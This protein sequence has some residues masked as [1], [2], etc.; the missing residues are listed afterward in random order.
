[1][2]RLEEH[3]APWKYLAPYLARHCDAIYDGRDVRPFLRRARYL[4][5]ALVRER[6]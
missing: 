4:A 5:G 1:M 2:T 6:R 3:H